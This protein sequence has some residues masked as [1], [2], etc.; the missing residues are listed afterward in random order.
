MLLNPHLKFLGEWGLNSD[1][2]FL[3]LVPIEGSIIENLPFLGLTLVEL[4][5]F[6]SNLLSTD[7]VLDPVLKLDKDFTSARL[8]QEPSGTAIT[9]LN[10][11]WV[12]LVSV[13]GEVG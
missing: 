9:P 3:D 10:L 13:F 2:H 4:L 8:I 12:V 11:H 1:L 5:L 6:L 7:H